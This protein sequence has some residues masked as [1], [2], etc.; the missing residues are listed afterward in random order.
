[1]LGI[2]A[3]YSRYSYIYRIYFIYIKTIL[4][5]SHRSSIVPVFNV[6]LNSLSTFYNDFCVDGILPKK[7]V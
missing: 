1:M 4:E 5:R 2:K 6:V 7:D 3:R